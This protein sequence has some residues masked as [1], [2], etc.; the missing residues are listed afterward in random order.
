M[1]VKLLFS[2]D[3]KEKGCLYFNIFNLYKA[4]KQLHNKE[5]LPLFHLIHVYLYIFLN[6]APG[7]FVI[8][9][10]NQIFIVL[11]YKC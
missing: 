5:L 10:T 4:F 1:H 8:L 9:E 7:N 3:W 6:F 2:T 11:P